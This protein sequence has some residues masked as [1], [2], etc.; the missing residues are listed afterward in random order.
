[1]NKTEV[2][3]QVSEKSGVS[4][5]ICEKIL[6]GLEKHIDFGDAL[7]M[8]T[9]S[10]KDSYATVISKHLH[11]GGISLSDCEKVLFAFDEVLGNGIKNKLK[12][13]K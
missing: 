6:K 2:I 12:F 5:D 10:L 4:C 7:K 8:L 11:N 3:T 9:S 13:F 1:M